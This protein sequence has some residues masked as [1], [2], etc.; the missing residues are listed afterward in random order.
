M[1]PF[2][3]LSS[4]VVYRNAP[5]VRERV[6][7]LKSWVLIRDL[8]R[9]WEVNIGR[10]NDELGQDSI[11]SLLPVQ[12]ARIMVNISHKVDKVRVRS[13]SDVSCASALLLPTQKLKN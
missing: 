2:K 9:I 10:I 8:V 11:W 3:E 6:Q 7:V 4:A 1:F 5:V 13:F 12:Y